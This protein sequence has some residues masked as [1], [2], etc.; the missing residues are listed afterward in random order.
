MKETDARDFLSYFDRVKLTPDCINI[1]IIKNL[2][3]GKSAPFS[4]PIIKLD[5]LN[6]YGLSGS[7]KKPE[8]ERDFSSRSKSIRP[9]NTKQ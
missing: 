3:K 7:E 8:K 9:R 5:Y 1:F 4:R 6:A 2:N